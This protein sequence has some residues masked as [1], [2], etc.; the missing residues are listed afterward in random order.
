[1][2]Q[3]FDLREFAR[4]LS[5]MKKRIP[6]Y[7]LSLVMLE[8]TLSI[9]PVIFAF[10]KRDMVNAAIEGEERVLLKGVILA[11]I[12][13]ALRCI[14]NPLFSYICS[15]A[16]R[17]SIKELKIDLFKKVE[18]LPMS[19]FTSTHSGDIVSVIT[20]DMKV[21]EDA[22]WNQMCFL[23]GAIFM[24]ISSAIAMF[25]LDF[26]LAIGLIVVGFLTTRLSLRFTKSI[27]T[28]SNAI[29]KNISRLN[30]YSKD[31]LGAI[32]VI[33][34]FQIGERYLNTFD[35][36]YHEYATNSIKCASKNAKV[37]AYN[38]CV[39]TFV[40]FAIFFVGAI[41]STK[42]Y[43]DFG[44][45][46]AM[47][48]LQG[49][50]LFAFT[51]LGQFINQ[52]QA[53]LAGADRIFDL[54]ELENES[55]SQRIDESKVNYEEIVC[56]QVTFGYDED[57][58]ILK[59]LN[60]VVRKGDQ[61]VLTGPSG[62]GKSTVLKLLL[63]L[64]HASSG[65][66]CIQGKDLRSYQIKELRDLITYI[67]Q[68]VY[69]FDG[70]IEENIKLGKQNATRE[71]VVK[72]AVLAGANDFIMELDHG[73]D[74]SAGENGER[75]SGGQR[76][77]IAIARAFLKNTPIL[78][79]DEATSALDHESEKKVQ[80]ALNVLVRGKTVIRVS[81]RLATIK[82]DEYV[83]MIKGGR[84]VEQGM[85]SKLLDQKGEYYKLFSSQSHLNLSA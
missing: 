10:I 45:V 47:L 79:M 82:E 70:T 15:R 73:Y 74:T 36:I 49:G 50:I 21:V 80:E 58:M 63:G 43:V 71:E 14:L 32:F 81:H 57:E 7:L 38:Y 66:I 26:R 3:R 51:G 56:N 72:A 60:L 75:L 23:V 20:N 33:K 2:K 44:T 28:C 52:L 5:L 35:N 11:M 37:S 68:E 54:L 8:L 16:V 13:L 42:G 22:L 64:Y 9:H 19:Y 53:S 78:L 29:Q 39:S 83:Y 18:N 76:Q 6:V 62:G 25:R 61:I 17:V 67:P 1:M 24:G 31:L 46:T 59:G 41:F 85:H 65:M 84:V 77:R 34:I 4:F 40:M 55:Q 30:Q 69:M 27:R 48:S 12:L